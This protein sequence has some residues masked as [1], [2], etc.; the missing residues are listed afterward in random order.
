MRFLASMNPGVVFQVVAP[1][2]RGRTVGAPVRLLAGV[3]AHMLA[4][5]GAPDKFL[6]APLALELSVACMY[7][8]V[9]V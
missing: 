8:F 7:Q 3:R 2:K 6:V 4:Q 9:L 1:R 5:V